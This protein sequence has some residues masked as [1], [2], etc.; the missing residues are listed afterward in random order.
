[1]NYQENVMLEEVLW[2][3]HHLFKLQITS[4]TTNKRKMQK[5]NMLMQIK[6]KKLIPWN[7][8]FGEKKE[9]NK[10]YILVNKL[11]FTYQLEEAYPP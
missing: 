9:Q 5:I 3:Q 4:N 11:N 2:T 8:L 10:T 6:I 7:W 1:M